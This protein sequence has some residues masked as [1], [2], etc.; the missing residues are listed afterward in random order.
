MRNKEQEEE[1]ESGIWRRREDHQN[2]MYSIMVHIVGHLL[3]YI[4]IR[5]SRRR[6]ILCR[7]YTSN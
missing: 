1:L 4:R 7:R 3:E 5:M 2:Q 6:G